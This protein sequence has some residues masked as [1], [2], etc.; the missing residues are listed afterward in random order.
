MMLPLALPLH[1]AGLNLLLIDARNHGQ[2]DVDGIS[3]MPRFAEDVQAALDWLRQAHPQRARKV[4][5]LGHSVGAAAVLLAAA[6]VAD[7]GDAGSAIGAVIAIASFSHP[8]KVMGRSLQAFHVPRLLHPLLLAY[9]QWAIGR[10]FDDIAP[11][12]TICRI[13]APVLLVHG[14][15]DTTVPIDDAREIID[16]CP[17]ANR[18]LLVVPGAGHDSVEA[19]RRHEPALI[20][21]LAEQGFDLNQP[22]T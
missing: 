7:G 8:R 14:D 2:S 10:R 11:V 21:F 12:N 16:A 9:V 13:Q 17:R 6:D 4:G 22:G 20:R 15:A 5:L 18:R 3:S 1:R 19:I